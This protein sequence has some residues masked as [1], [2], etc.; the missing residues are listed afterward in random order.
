M[1][2]E[3][4][5]AKLKDLILNTVKR[6]QAEIEKKTEEIA[7]LTEEMHRMSEELVEYRKVIE[8]IREDIQDKDQSLLAVEENVRGN[9]KRLLTVE[10]NV[11][12]NNERLLAIEESIHGNDERFLTL[13]ESVR[14][15]NERLLMVEENTRGNNE[16]LDTVDEKNRNNNERLLMVEENVRGNNNI[17]EQLSDRDIKALEVKITALK[18]QIKKINSTEGNISSA[19]DV[20][21]S[22]ESTYNDLDYFAFENYFR[23]SEEL[24]K[25]RQRIY[26]PYFDKCSNVLDLGCGRG[27]FIELLQEN[28]IEAKGIDFYEEFVVYD[29]S[30]GLNVESG[31]AISYLENLQDKVDGIFAGQLVEHLSMGQIIAL[32]ENAYEKLEEGKYL[33]METPNP[34]SL[35]IY[36]HAFYIDPSHQKPIHPLTLKYVVEQAGFKDVQIVFTE[37]SKLSETIPPLMGSGISNLEEF[38]ASMQQVANYLYGSQDYAVIAKK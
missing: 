8:I 32:C 29:Q 28:G 2:F 10:E 7:L 33:I 14:G 37:A 19:D 12:G 16:R 9:S 35:A 24:I 38:N 23:G 17:L 34:T 4:Q 3:K 30:R 1:A 27:E 26:L 20:I 22:S 6:L 13:E 15:N 5:K 11:R 25:E 31:D 21:Q 18:A 36:T